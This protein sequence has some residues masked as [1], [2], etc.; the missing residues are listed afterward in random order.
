MI[1]R[2]LVTLSRSLLGFNA[3]LSGFASCEHKLHHGR[4]VD[5]ALSNDNISYTVFCSYIDVT[6]FLGVNRIIAFP[7]QCVVVCIVVY[8]QR[9]RLRQ[10]N[11]IPRQTSSGARVAPA[12]TET[13]YTSVRVDLMEPKS[14]F[15]T[16]ITSF[17]VH[18][19]LV[20]HNRDK[21]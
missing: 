10:S 1:L 11:L 14:A 12:E 17:P 5:T 13:R 20:V 18:V 7:V 2:L 3:V 8:G 9:T 19:H 6:D 4:D 21:A 16:F 15:F